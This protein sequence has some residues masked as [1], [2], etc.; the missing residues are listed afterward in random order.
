MNLYQRGPQN[1]KFLIIVCPVPKINAL[2]KKGLNALKV[3]K[4]DEAIAA[5]TEAIALDGQNYVLFS[6][7][8]AAYATAG[9]NKEALKDAEQAIVLNPTWPKGYLRKGDALHGMKKCREASLSYKK[10]RR[11]WNYFKVI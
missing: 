9:K 5:Y 1:E 3:D 4:V 10:G 11:S 8:S 7:R 2:K 6:N